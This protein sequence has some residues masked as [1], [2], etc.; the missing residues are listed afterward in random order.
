MILSNDNH[1]LKR[2]MFQ[3]SPPQIL[4]SGFFVLILLGTFLLKLPFATS[5]SISWLDAVFT[6]TSATTVTGLAVVDTGTTFTTFGEV[7]IMLLMQF[8]GL[9]FMTFAVLFF[10][11]FK[12][13]IGL[14]ERVLIQ[15]SLNQT[16]LGGL[17][18]LVK[19]LFIFSISIEAIGFIL[20]SI[21]WVPAFGWQTGMYQ[22]LFHT[23]AS[24]NNAGFSLWPDNL[25][26]YAGDPLVN[27]VITGLFI[28]G[29]IGFTVLVDLW[30]KKN[31]KHLS[32]HSKMMLVGTLGINV[33]A[34][35][36][37]FI[38]EYSN[39]GTLGSLSLPD[40]L[41][42]AYF[43]A[44]T[45][46]T[47]GFNSI[48]IGAMTTPSLLLMMLLMFVGAG[49]SSTASGIKVTT[50]IVLILATYSYLRGKDETIIYN[51]AIKKQAILKALA[52]TI[53]SFMLIFV[54][55][56]LLTITENAPFL[57]IVFEVVSA[58]GTVGLTTGITADLTSIGKCII[59]VMMF[60]G[61]IGPL[62]IAFLFTKQKSSSIR[63]P[64]EDI[65]IG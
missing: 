56:F 59:I 61:R 20:L 30:N 49:S 57:S 35:L 63:Y 25:T 13:K 15:E 65:F 34:T 12:K 10:L 62:T 60:I 33:I 18:Q 4:A 26:S 36:L 5:A 14:Q 29:G 50:F 21:K 46:R 6:A 2:R 40:K 52:I 53:I 43:Q 1:P 8:G 55:I 3:L 64:E 16:A 47:A 32:L 28:T 7:I 42:G 9:G 19:A 23:I 11:M 38:L 51:R 24:F 44:V 58:F 22:S 41:W 37:L 31:F 45:T 54:T 17:V 39:P 48:D 27:I